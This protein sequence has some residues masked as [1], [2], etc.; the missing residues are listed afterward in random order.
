[1]KRVGYPIDVS[2]YLWCNFK[3]WEGPDEAS[4]S[5]GA[6]ALHHSATFLS[7]LPVQAGTL[8][9]VHSGKIQFPKIASVIH[10]IQKCVDIRGDADAWNHNKIEFRD[11]P[12]ELSSQQHNDISKQIESCEYKNV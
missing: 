9:E 7:D 4:V 10:V 3:N 1:M 6:G 2:V 5:D 12:D 11:A 8:I